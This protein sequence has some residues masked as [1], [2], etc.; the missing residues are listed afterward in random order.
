MLV[1]V[2]MNMEAGRWDLETRRDVAVAAVVRPRG[3]QEDAGRPDGQHAHDRLEFLDSVHSR[4]PPQLWFAGRL[5]VAVCHDG[6]PVKETARSEFVHPTNIH[7]V[8]ITKNLTNLLQLIGVESRSGGRRCLS[9]E[10]AGFIYQRLLRV[11]GRI[12]TNISNPTKYVTIE[13]GRLSGEYMV[14]HLIP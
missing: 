11:Q 12:T 3:H 9:K 2:K 14:N 5:Q 10:V 1:L 8:A 13:L 7:C 4:Q 6:C